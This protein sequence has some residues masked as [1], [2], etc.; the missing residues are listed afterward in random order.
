MGDGVEAGDRWFRDLLRRSLEPDR[1]WGKDVL[2]NAHEHEHEADAIGAKFFAV[3]FPERT[4]IP[5]VAKDED[6][7][8][9]VSQGGQIRYCSP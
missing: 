5:R 2:G 6:D 1:K 4:R 3:F 8:K 7:L 9:R